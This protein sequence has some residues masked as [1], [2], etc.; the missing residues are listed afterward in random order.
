MSA[1]PVVKTGEEAKYHLIQKNI[2]KVGL[3]ER[4]QQKGEYQAAGDYADKSATVK[5]RFSDAIQCKYGFEV[6]DADGK[7]AIGL[8]SGNGKRT[9][10]NGSAL[11]DIPQK[12]G[13]MA[14][15]ENLLGISQALT[16]VMQ[17]R[18][19][20]VVYRND[21]GRPITVAVSAVIASTSGLSG[22][23]LYVDG[24]AHSSFAVSQS[25]FPVR[26]NVFAIIPPNS[27]YQLDNSAGI[28]VLTWTELR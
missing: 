9:L 23:T 17:Y 12:S 25:G 21:I 7:V 15:N 28:S 2:S 13:T 26:S 20:G 24:I 6:T 22:S 5:Q 4:F 19:P 10:T 18:A 1:S 14:L 27:T 16:N 8:Y 3:P 11:I